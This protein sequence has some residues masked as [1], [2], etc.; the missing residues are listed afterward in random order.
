[1]PRPDSQR[2][3][4]APREGLTPGTKAAVVSLVTVVLTMTVALW[5]LTMAWEIWLFLSAVVGIGCAIV[6]SGIRLRVLG[7]VLIGMF[8]FTAA[9]DEVLLG[10]VNVRQLCLV[11][12]GLLLLTTLDPLHLPPVPWWLHAY[13]LAAV[14]ATGF[15]LL[16]PVSQAYLDS[17]YATSASGQS[18]GER[19]G[20]I[21]S[22]ASLLL[23]NYG[24]P[25]VIVLAC[26]VMPKALKWLIAS[27]VVGAAFC[28]LAA[29]LGYYGM[30]VLMNTFG[31]VAWPSGVR[32]SG[33]TSHPL[34][35]ATAGMMGTG[36]ACWMA[37]QKHTLLKWGGWGSLPLL[38]GGLYVS[39]SRG[40]ALAGMLVLVLSM[41]LLPE[42]RRRVHEV[43]GTV[44]VAV[45][46][47]LFAFPSVVE[48]VLGQTRLAGDQTTSVS[49]TGRSEVLLQ[50]L[51]DFNTSPIFGIGIQFIA[52]AHTLYVGVLAAGGIILGVGFVLFNIGSVIAAVQSLKMDRA[53]AGALLATLGATLFYWTVADLIQTKTV[54][55]IYAF[56][57]ALWWRGKDDPD[58]PPVS[59]SDETMDSTRAEAASVTR[60]RPT[61]G[62]TP[63]MPRVAPDRLNF[64]DG[65]AS[66]GPGLS[67]TGG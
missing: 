32:A 30:P 22:L 1:M 48:S 7:V 59:E 34:R 17:R 14:V 58:A 27:Y 55:I 19:E 53:L 62:P 41:F 5:S 13:G 23:N 24:V 29:I 9:W 10:S 21:P 49:D 47:L 42:V 50:G 36:L 61:S 26:M 12:G 39:G 43:V 35:L 51:D 67:V 44:A 8:C 28:C 54:A 38:L 11:L 37:L 56:V 6:I 64:P 20:T 57:V 18:L 31:G 16:F 63:S 3:R 15:Q 4:R 66:A 52:E 2:P 65:P 45:L 46:A 33:F 40:G 60:G 25:V